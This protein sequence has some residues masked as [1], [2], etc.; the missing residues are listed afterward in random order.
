MIAAGALALVAIIV[1]TYVFFGGSSKPATNA[2]I[3]SRSS[4]PAS[5]ML[6]PRDAQ[7][8][9]VATADDAS[10]YQ[11]IAYSGSVA[12]VSEGDRNIFAY[13]EPPPPTP[14]VVIV[15]T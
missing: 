3:V 10:I 2:N 5:R 6:A 9:Y 11:P 4:P 14:K 12:A 15:P 13:Y 7:Q 1:L 8:P